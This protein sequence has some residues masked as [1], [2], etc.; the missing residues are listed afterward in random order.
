MAMIKM[1]SFCVSVATVQGVLRQKT[2]QFDMSAKPY[3]VL[4]LDDCFA[5]KECD[6]KK[7]ASAWTSMMQEK[8]PRTEE[9]TLQV[10]DWQGKNIRVAANKRLAGQKLSIKVF[11]ANKQEASARID[12]KLQSLPD[13]ERPDLD[14]TILDLWVSELKPYEMHL[15]AL[16]VDT[17]M[18]PAELESVAGV[19]PNDLMRFAKYFCF[20][21]LR[22]NKLTLVDLSSF[23][24][25]NRELKM[26]EIDQRTMSAIIG[27]EYPS[28]YS[29]K[30]S[31]THDVSTWNKIRESSR[32]CMKETINDEKK[33]E[34]FENA[35]ALSWRYCRAKDTI[36][37]CLTK[38]QKQISKESVPFSGS[39]AA[40]IQQ[41][42]FSSIRDEMERDFIHLLEDRS[43]S[44]SQKLEKLKVSDDSC[45]LWNKNVQDFSKQME[46]SVEKYS[47]LQQKKSAISFPK[48]VRFHSDP[49]SR[50]DGSE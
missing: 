16:N 31:F 39:K 45:L 11:I 34:L 22:C 37:A 7:Q 18:T 29:S 17:Q 35:G 49:S 33:I 3:N 9:I 21:V 50:I 41:N 27:K 2:I 20:E 40:G 43:L 32:K 6:E 5:N 44:F 48:K 4:G 1:S 47:E 42:L 19:S 13:D 30:Y 12:S 10:K 24:A 8:F 38:L 14:E 25:R 23:V 46:L 28:V 36:K 26:E 15:Q